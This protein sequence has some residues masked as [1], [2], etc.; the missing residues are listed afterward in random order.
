M[1]IKLFEGGYVPEKIKLP[2]SG[3]DIYMPK[4]FTIRPFETLTLP[5]GIGV[6]IPEGCT[7]LIVPRSSIAEKGLIIQTSAID[8]DYAG[9]IHL[10]VTNCS[11]NTYIIAQHDRICSLIVYQTLNARIEIVDELQSKYRKTNG[12]GSSG[13]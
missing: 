7:G 10:I 12:L 1:D 5:L 9:E 8:P 4:G 3:I 2:D 6:S 13:K 11:P